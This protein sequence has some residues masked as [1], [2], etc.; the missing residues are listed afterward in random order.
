MTR[1][2]L[3]GKVDWEG[4]KKTDPS[5][6]LYFSGNHGIMGNKET[7]VLSAEEQLFNETGWT[8]RCMS[9]CYWEKEHRVKN[10]LNFAV[11][12]GIK[13][14]LDSGAFTLQSDPN[15]TWQ[16]VRAYAER[17]CKFLDTYRHKVHWY[18]GLDW[19]RDAAT[20]WEAHHMMQGMGYY[21]VP[22]YHGN[23]P[24]SEYKRL[25]DTGFPLIA[26]AKP[27]KLWSQKSWLTGKDLRTVYDQVHHLAEPYK[28]ALHGLAQT[29][30]FMFSYPWYSVDSTNWLAGCKNG[31]LFDIDAV[32]GRINAVYIGPQILKDKKQNPKKVYRSPDWEALDIQT[33]KRLMAVAKR[34]G[35]TDQKLLTDYQT[36]CIYNVRVLQESIDA[37]A[38]KFHGARYQKV[39]L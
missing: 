2:K 14:F 34:Y 23:D 18:A 25:L 17:Y 15:C 38:F 21:P 29:G 9:Y 39:L 19:R 11:N 7:G 35:M 3:S 26:I 16:T 24:I 1:K 33:K 32:H 6:I 37:G 12:H 8:H 30:K 28:C 5:P 10:A 27:G 4:R 13:V 20:S 22:V 31:Q 36:R